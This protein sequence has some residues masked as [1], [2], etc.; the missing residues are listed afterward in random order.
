MAGLP[1][2]CRIQVN[3]IS[4]Y[5]AIKNS[6]SH[7]LCVRKLSFYYIILLLSFLLIS[8]PG[9]TTDQVHHSTV[10]SVLPSHTFIVTARPS[11]TIH[12]DSGSVTLHTG[13][14]DAVIVTATQ[15]VSDLNTLNTPDA[16]YTPDA[17]DMQVNYDQQGNTI[18]VEALNISNAALRTISVDFD[19]FVPPGSDVQVYAGYGSIDADGLHGRTTLETH[20]G[21]IAVRNISG[22]MTINGTNG[23]VSADNIQGSLSLSLSNGDVALRHVSLTGSSQITTEHGSIDFEGSIESHGSYRFHTDIGT[24]DLTLPTSSSFDLDAVTGRGS[25]ENEFGSTH[26]G[27]YDEPRALLRISSELGSI[28]LH[29][30]S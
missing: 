25:I 17:K 19:V 20:D 9:C 26:V 30:G 29:D 2:V 3:I 6:Y 8:L 1:F 16:Q 12:N 14:D 21:D 27:N 13:K 4:H 10:R 23:F 15:H 7:I 24:I 22:P 5:K 18:S 28:S 11:L